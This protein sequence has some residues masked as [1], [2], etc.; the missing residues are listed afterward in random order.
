MTI[1]AIALAAFGIGILV[2]QRWGLILAL[3]YF[4][5]VVI[6]HILFFVTNFSVP[7]QAV[8]VEITAI[9]GPIVFLILLYL[10]IRSRPLLVQA[11]T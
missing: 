9:E 6:S 7:S 3:L 10:W 2:H 5:E 4:A 8:H 11:L 1:Q